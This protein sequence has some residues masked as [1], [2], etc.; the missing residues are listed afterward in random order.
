MSLAVVDRKAVTHSKD[1]GLGLAQETLFRVVESLDRTGY[2]PLR[3]LTLEADDA[4]VVTISGQ[5][6]NFFMRQLALSAVKDTPGVACVRDQ[7]R[8][9][10]ALTTRKPLHSHR[11][12]WLDS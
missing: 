11:L 1:D 12:I 3:K 9:E 10:N 2:L 6:P 4:G 8:V 7:L 5:V